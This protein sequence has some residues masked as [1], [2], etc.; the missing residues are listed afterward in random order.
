MKPHRPEDVS[1]VHAAEWRLSACSGKAGLS[2]A[3]AQRIVERMRRKHDERLV[4]YRCAFCRQWH[5]GEA[6]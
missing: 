1:A 6:M 2:F 4:T 3:R 5:V